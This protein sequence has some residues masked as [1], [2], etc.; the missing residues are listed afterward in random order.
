M[1]EEEILRINNELKE[2]KISIVGIAAVNKSNVMGVDGK[3]PWNCK[4]E[5]KFFKRQTTDRIVVMGRKTFESIGKPLKNR[6]NIIF[7]SQSGE[8]ENCIFIKSLEEFFEI[9]LQEEDLDVSIIGGRTIYELFAPFM[10]AFILSTVET[11]EAN[12]ELEEGSEVCLFP[13]H[14]FGSKKREGKYRIWEGFFFETITFQE[15]YRESFGKKSTQKERADLLE[16]FKKSQ[17]KID[18]PVFLM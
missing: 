3:M 8:V 5:M 11:E 7:S 12:K 10:K 17:K 1:N 15:W 6:I 14:I 2:K 18:K 4:N 13:I 16:K 9:I